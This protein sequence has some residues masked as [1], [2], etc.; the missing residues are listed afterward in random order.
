MTAGARRLP[1]C[2]LALL[3]LLG[4][5]APAHAQQAG[6][7]GRVT[8][9]RSGEPVQGALVSVEG[10]DLRTRTDSGGQY[11]IAGVPVGSYVLRVQLLSFAPRRIDVLL[12]PGARLSIDIAIERSALQVQGVRVVADPAGRARG[13][14]GTASVIEREAI[15]SQ[16]AASLAGVLEL[17]PGVVVQPPGLDGIQQIALRASPI[18]GGSS[19]LTDQDASNVSAFGTLIVLDDVPLSN[20]ANVQSLGARSELAFNSTAGVGIDLRRLPATTIE[21]VEVIRGVPSS[22]WGDLT[23][24]AIIVD[25]RAGAVEPEIAARADASTTEVSLVGGREFRSQA[26]TL[27]TNAA[28][29]RTGTA[30]GDEALRL[31]GQLAHRW[32]S[33][34]GG[35]D[36]PRLSLDTRVD[37][38]RLQDVRPEN[39]LVPGSER[40]S[41]DAAFRVLERARL[42]V[43]S[44]STLHWTAA[45][46]RG[47][48]QYWSRRNF[49]RGVQA[50]TTRS[51]PGREIGRFEGGIYNARIDVNG[52]PSQLYSRLELQ[53]APNWRALQHDLRIGTELRR[54][55][56]GGSGQSFDL[57]FP[58]QVQMVGARGFDRPRRF[59]TL[60][61]FITSSV[62]ADDRV[63]F[64]MPRGG[65]A[66]VQA[67]VRLDALHEPGEWSAAPRSV[68][69]QP[70]ANVEYVPTP[71]L[72]L[73]AGAGRSAKT[74][75]LG[76]LRPAPDYYDVVNVNYFA[77][78]PAERLAVL[79]TFVLDPTNPS[80]RHSE[81]DRAEAGIEARVKGALITLTAYADRLEGGHGVQPEA[82]AVV[83]DNF[84]LTGTQPGSGRPPTVVEPA[85]SQDSI[86][87][88]ISRTANNITQRGSGIELTADLPEIPVVKTRFSIQGSLA[89]SQLLPD[90]IELPTSFRDFQL[91][92]SI[93]RIPYYASFERTG[94]LGLITARAI[95]QQAEL[96]LVI[97]AMV[98]F[99]ARERQQNLGDTDSLAFEGYFTRGGT[100]VAVPRDQRNQP[101]YAD[102]RASRS[103]FTT[104][105]SGQ[106][107]WLLSLQVAKTLPANGRLAFYAFNAFDRPGRF[108]DSETLLRPFAATRFGMELTVPLTGLTPWR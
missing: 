58:P 15:R 35:D 24:G 98:Q 41:V 87:V 29:T 12:T 37:G 32:A 94:E 80:L 9:A 42:R 19:S 18:A 45:Y 48:Q 17:V 28:R 97:T 67:G 104:V 69:A 33:A 107:D 99:T 44:S 86:P 108:G 84:A 20:N 106:P 2:V 8:V 88:L 63:R 103:T 4:M 23:H 101:Q 71:W 79:T 92:P 40:R 75:S 38:Y 65:W 74:P 59:D 1:P 36:T 6:I 102:L 95:H 34:A 49:V 54:E 13:E 46:E 105:R 82:A 81:M 5:A 96:G 60:P 21:R 55:A 25:T 52:A 27:T 53:S 70:R 39:T 72:S 93:A 73:R 78:A 31:S 43:G 3:V 50:L 66:I 10:T 14:T 56:N 47:T 83:R 51:T 64:V 90:R 62:Y 68:V 16:V 91:L 77:N 30:L 89:R 100:L 26:L 11:L 61:S 85:I 7:S 76:A 57:L 22:R